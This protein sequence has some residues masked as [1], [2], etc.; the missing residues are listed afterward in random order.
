MNYIQNKNILFVKYI[1]DQRFVSLS[2]IL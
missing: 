1:Q 2:T